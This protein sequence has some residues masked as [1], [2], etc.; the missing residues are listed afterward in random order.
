MASRVDPSYSASR[1][2]KSG[3]GH[4]ILPYITG[5]L[6]SDSRFGRK[7]NEVFKHTFV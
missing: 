6:I 3:F 2:E 5:V 7:I 1:G 4:T